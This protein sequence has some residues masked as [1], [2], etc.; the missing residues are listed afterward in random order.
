MELMVG[1]EKIVSYL[2]RYLTNDFIYFDVGCSG[3]IDAQWFSLE[4]KL[5]AVGFDVVVAEIDRLRALNTHSRVEYVSGAVSGAKKRKIASANPWSRLAVCETNRIRSQQTKN[6]K[7]VGIVDN[8]WQAEEAA[9]DEIFLPGYMDNNGYTYLDFLKI[10]VDGQ[11]FDIL[12]SLEPKLESA[13]ILGICIEVNYH[14][15]D[16]PD[17]NTFHNVDRFMR[18]NGYALFD[19]TKRLYSGSFLPAPYEISIPAQ[20]NFGRPLQGDALYIRD[21]CDPNYKDSVPITKDRLLKVIIINV[22]FNKLDSAA[23]ILLNYSEIFEASFSTSFVLD[24]LTKE[25]ANK[26]FSQLNYTD[27]ISKFESDDSIFYPK[28]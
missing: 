14:G 23:E 26:H 4:D 17:E 24:M 16:D 19:F 7:F 27:L 21:I 15:S 3:G 2:S 5:V 28:G 12:T 6:S 11:D 22:L 9:V 20:A 13:D 25:W 18:A 1:S 10:D 8:N